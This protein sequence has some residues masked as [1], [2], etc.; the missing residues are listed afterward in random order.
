MVLVFLA[1][2][3]TICKSDPLSILPPFPQDYH[4]LKILDQLL[5]YLCL[6]DSTAASYSYIHETSKINDHATGTN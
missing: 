2:S 5:I 1:S 4:L 6:N 3:Q